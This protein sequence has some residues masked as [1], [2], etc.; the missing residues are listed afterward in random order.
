MPRRDYDAFEQALLEARA[1]AIRE[2]D[3][4]AGLDVVRDLAQ[5][6][7]VKG[8]AGVALADAV[9]GKY[10]AELIPVL[11]DTE[12]PDIDLAWSYVGRRIRHGDLDVE[13]QLDP[14]AGLS[15]DVHARLLLMGAD[16]KAAWERADA[17]GED[18]AASFWRNFRPYGLGG[19]SAAVLDVATRLMDSGRNAAALDFLDMYRDREH[20]SSIEIARLVVR[21]LQA[22]LQH[23]DDEI[24]SLSQYDF[25]SMFEVL[26]SHVDQLGADVVGNLEWAY[27][28]GDW[29]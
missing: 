2:V 29:L 26:E 25:S 20:G 19:D 1:A 14:A 12:H 24:Q 28:P 23:P 27:L 4:E 17:L 21:G 15:S 9:G 7:T 18:V 8:A 10:D 3:E 22:L 13:A 11:G 16:A 6:A 5:S